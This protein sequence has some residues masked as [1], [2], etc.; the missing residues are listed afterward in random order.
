MTIK[1]Q[2]IIIIISMIFFA[3][4]INSFLS[5]RYIDN[6]FKGYVTEQ[7]EDEVDKI[8]NYAIKLLNND[9]YT[10]E[11]SKE[12]LM[13]FI[14]EFIVQIS[15][16]NE[17]AEELVK[18]YNRMYFMHN[19]M[20][21][22]RNNLEVDYYELTYDEKVIGAIKITRTA[23]IQNS[24]SVRLFK[25]ALILATVISGTIVLVLA[26]II[27]AIISTRI[28]KD[29]RQ[30]AKFAKEIETESEE[31][32][33]YSK[34]IEIRGI[35][36]SLE[37]LASRLR[38]QKK[39]RQEKVDQLSHEARTP[40]TILKAHCEGT[41][42]GVVEMDSNRLESCLNEINNL[43]GI[44]SN[45]NNVIEYNNEV[46]NINKETFDLIDEF[47]KIIRGLKIQ[48][49]QKGIELKLKG[50]LNMKIT[51]DKALLSQTIYNLLTNAY[52]FTRL[53][54]EVL[55]EIDNSSQDSLY[56]AVHDNGIGI[57]EK[58]IKRIFEPYYRGSD[59][60]NIQGDGLGL[61]IS[62]TNIEAI[63]GTIQVK[64][65]EKEGTSFVIQIPY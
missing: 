2:L 24:E 53:K 43:S 42:D 63:G 44:M 13:N 3:I 36:T 65:N 25:K 11:K 39:V 47:K 64:S 57:N 22:N 58:D 9:N 16:E 37:N 4:I 56:I 32:I 41:I 15:I 12:E 52:K 59:T 21:G 27:T 18:V 10:A 34:V 31:R 29:L 26:V 61:Y 7:Y 55:I 38:M 17:S 19:N 48:Y 46:V 20:M 54:G 30:T 33:N 49:E 62:K 8:K 14:D 51:T 5:S 60:N 35:Q 40:L 50:P 6:Y 45:L 28:T 1:K 23:S